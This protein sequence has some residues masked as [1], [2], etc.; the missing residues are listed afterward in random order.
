M[1]RYARQIEALA[2]KGQLRKLTDTEA[3]KKYIVKE[4]KPM[5]N[6]S[7]NDYLGLAS[8]TALRQAFF[9]S[10]PAE[11]LLLTAASSRLLTGNH[12]SYRRL[13][14]LLAR[15]YGKPAAMVFNS[16]YHANSGILPAVTDSRTLILA[17]KLVHA[18]LIEGIL[19]SK[20]A[21]IRY[22]HN[23]YCHLEK[24]L[25]DK[26][27]LYETVI[28]VTESIFSMDGDTCDLDRLVSFK[29]EYPN[30]LLY[31]D[32]A[33]AVGVRGDKGL[34]LCEERHCIDSIDFLVVTFGKALA[35][36]GAAV[37]CSEEM[38]TWLVNTVRPF[39]FTTALPP[40]N[41]EWTCFVLSHL[42]EMQ[43]R[44]NHL[45][46]IA[47]RVCR[48]L[49]PLNGAYRSESHIV[50][51]IV[52]DAAKA[53]EEAVRIQ[54]EGFYLLPVRPPT[55]PQGTSRLR[56][57]LNATCS[58]EEATLLIKTLTETKDA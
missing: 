27:R 49:N 55:V 3:G 51:Y 34:G 53:Q 17:D 21:T 10:T 12:P 37:L 57:S 29:K 40:I 5:L 25:Q 36:V 42:H 28:I 24:L 48:A 32:E 20:S 35:S 39:I 6:L 18:S 33:H 1:S 4:G 52:G 26:A 58:D 46:S 15:L 50:P 31:I 41:V 11:R 23:D 56:I 43:E 14:E 9:D 47:S 54:R 13:E 22:R 19:L 38:K 8:D 30:V 16:G 2:E 44:R 45:K 7:S